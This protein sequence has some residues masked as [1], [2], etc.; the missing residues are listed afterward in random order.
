MVTL[1]GFGIGV[2]NWLSLVL[3]LATGFISFVRRIAIEDCA[4]SERF[5]KHYEEYRERTWALVPFIW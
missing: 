1:L 3:L 2:G 4:L 5:G